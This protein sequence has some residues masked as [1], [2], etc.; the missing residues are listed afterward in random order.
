MPTTFEKATLP[1]GLT[2]IAEID[3][4]AHTAAA[5]FFVRT[6]TRDEP[7]QLMGVSHFLEHMMFKGTKRRSAEDVNKA[8]D[9]MGAKANAYTSHELTAFYAGVLP[10]Q[11]E[12]AGELLSDIM[13][14][15]LREEDFVTEKGVILEEIAMYQ[16]EPFWVLYEA[17]SEKHFGKHP[18][19][20]RVL[21]TQQSITD[22]TSE[23]MRG[24][25]EHRYSADNTTIA[26]AGRVD[27]DKMVKKFEQWCGHWPRTGATRDPVL[28]KIKRQE[29]TIE[30]DRFNQAYRML[31]ASAPASDDDRRHAAAIA[32]QVLG[33]SDNSRLHWAVVEPGLAE[34]ASSAYDVRDGLSDFRIMVVTD[35]E[36]LEK[37]W[38][39]VEKELGKVAREIN[40][41]EVALTRGKLKTAVTLAGEK[42]EG[43]MHRIGRNWTLDHRYTTLSEEL[44][45]LRAVTAKDV[46]KVLS[47]FPFS[48]ATM[49]TMTPKATA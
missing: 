19:G 35:P 11:L 32:M 1:N 42:P 9:D 48:P 36:K 37:S 2:L 49:G 5:G 18:L 14:P 6:G 3:P 28:P 25:F 44:E 15:A 27:F 8:F 47:E 41:Q 7:R 31:I 17:V 23:Q 33:A 30:S 26:M 16:D 22:L 10:E 45:K 34:E 40:E 46:R 21:G 38:A 12:Q 4:A 20:Y 29:L 39:I 43:R 13:R 24:Y